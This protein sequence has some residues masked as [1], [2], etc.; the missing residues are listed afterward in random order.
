M[1]GFEHG[2]TVDVYLPG[3]GKVGFLFQAGETVATDYDDNSRLTATLDGN[4]VAIAFTLEFP[5]GRKY[6][7]DYMD[8][9]TRPHNYYMSSA[10]DQ[11]GFVTRFNY[12]LVDGGHAGTMLRLATVADQENNL[13]FSLYYTNATDYS[14]LVS[15]VT[16]R[17][18]RSVQLT[19]EPDASGNSHLSQIQDAAGLPST[20]SYNDS[21]W[22]ETLVTPYGRTTFQYDEGTVGWWNVYR[23]VR[24]A[25]P[26][27]GSQTYLFTLSSGY[28]LDG[29]PW[30]PGELPAGLV[31]DNLP[32]GSTIDICFQNMNSFHWNQ[33]QNFDLPT[34]LAQ[35]TTNDFNKARMRHWLATCS[36]FYVPDF[37]LSAEVA[38]SQSDDGSTLG[39][40]TFYDYAG[41]PYLWPG[42]RGVN[43]QIQPSLIA[44]RLP[45]GSTWYTAYGRNS[46]GLPTSATSTYGTDNPA[47]TRTYAFTYAANGQDVVQVQGPGSVLLATY[48]Y[49]TRHQ[50][51]N[52]VLWPD[53]VISYTNAWSFDAQGR[54]QSKITA[55]GQTTTYTYNGSSG[56]YSGYLSG[57]SEQPVQRTESF[58]WLN[59]LIQGYTDYRGLAVTNFWDGLNRLTGTLYPDG[60]TTSNLYARATAYAN[61]TGG[62]N[63]LDPTGTRDR[64]G[65]WTGFDYDSLRRIT[66]RT[67][68]NGV[69]TR[70][71]YCDCGAASYITNAWGTPVQ[72]VTVFTFDNQGNRIMASYADGYSTT[73]WFNALG[74][75]AASGDGT[76]YRW[77]YYNN[78]G[79][80]TTVSNACGLE[81]AITF[82]IWDRGEYVTDANGVTVVNTYDTL[83]RI[84]A[85]GYPDNGAEWF[86]Y[87][88]RGLV[89][90]T[91]Q[92]GLSNFFAYDAAARKTYE[93]NANGE[94]I[95]YTNSAAGD[96]L[97]LT[98]GKSQTTC[99]TYD[100][101]GRV[102]NKLD[103]AG[104]QVLRYTYDGEGRLTNRWSTTKGNTAYAYDCVGNLTNINYPVSPDVTL[105]YDWL[106]RVTNMIDAAGT[107]KYTY[108]AANQLLTEDGPFTSDTVTNTY[109]NRLRVALGL[110]Q[111][112]GAW[113]NGFA[114]DA[115]SRLTNVTSQAGAFTNVYGTGVGGSSGF[116]SRLIQRQLLAN[117]AAITNNFDSVARILGTYLRTSGGVLTNKHEYLYNLAGQR[118]N[119][120][121]MDSSTVACR[122]DNI[123]Q[124]KVA[125]SSVNAEDRGYT[126]DAAWNL[127]YRTNNGS[128]TTFSVDSRNQ[129][130]SVAS[131]PDTYD[132]NGNLARVG[133][134]GSGMYVTHTY[135][136]EN[137][138]TEVATNYSNIQAPVGDAPALQTSQAWKSDFVYDGLGRLRKRLEYVNGTLQTTTCYIY[139]GWR[140]VQ[141]RDVNNTPTVSYTR[142][143]DPSGSLERAGGIGGLLARSS[144]YSSGNGNWS[145]HNVYHADG[146]GNVTFML[147]SS[148]AVVASYRY[149]PFG[150]TISSSGSLAT[151]NIYRFSSKEFHVNSGMYYYGYRF[152]DP[153]LQ[154][155]INRDPIQEQPGRQTKLRLIAQAEA[156]WNLYEFCLNQPPTYADTD[157]RSLWSWLGWL[158]H[159]I[160]ELMTPYGGGGT[161]C[162]KSS[163]DTFYVDNGEWHVLPAGKCTPFDVDCDGYMCGGKF[164]PVSN[165]SSGTCRPDCTGTGP[166]APLPNSRAPK[167]PPYDWPY[168]PIA[169][170]V[171]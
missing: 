28:L 168:G 114:Y 164:Y 166:S 169:G 171:R 134:T 153:Y 118:T 3:G 41:K 142:G 95:R 46:F 70:Y 122:Y 139:D 59:G 165:L 87:S 133:S 31:P 64:L 82:D 86:G 115:A 38:P 74:Q 97:S 77:F 156:G 102:T 150:N 88:A 99:W 21:A 161:C 96:L 61:G 92:I 2:T 17:F 14:S 126:F 78:Q 12:D 27:D 154:R 30:M 29:S 56:N 81:K 129:L 94:V 66:A 36:D 11:Q 159:Q 144:G 24:I 85:R 167:P 137:R 127:N 16:D 143:N 76:G 4:G 103:Q 65:H 67:N 23:R 35:F 45:D 34:D 140:V 69:V 131:T 83:G 90:Y 108:T 112:T 62:L 149:D 132:G 55:A 141:E 72:Q 123:G 124:L 119:E 54:L 136:D 157:G 125:D 111:P 147:N 145:T 7:Y 89:A 20:I 9:A 80:L 93:T 146:N 71:G 105:Q 43:T 39:Q 98:D 110:Q 52:E 162:N 22:P 113:T 107:T 57:T 63:I 152:Y 91:N 19:Y 116:S 40:I 170:A 117:H 101:Y 18:G 106:N 104:T 51:T 75:T 84:L 47:A 32:Q 25:E 58:T 79:L 5:D 53:S 44:R 49:N 138:L 6:V 109:Q 48:G 163:K 13:L 50:K 8:L 155:W 26:N 33:R 130:T 160:S 42:V 1:G 37:A 68:A 73:N 15:V 121:R 10:A 151:A 100:Q 60:T 135:D 128:T 158:K 120:T 148:Q